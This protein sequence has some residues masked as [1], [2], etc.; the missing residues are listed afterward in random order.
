MTVFLVI[1]HFPPDPRPIYER[2]QSNGRLSPEGLAYINSWVTVDLTK[3]YQVMEAADRSMLDEWMANWDDLV[4]F[5]VHEVLSSAEATK[6][7]MG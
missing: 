6:K 2:F 3:C 4:K 7:I 5:E 1:E